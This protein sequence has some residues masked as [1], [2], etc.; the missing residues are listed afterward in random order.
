[1]PIRGFEKAYYRVWKPYYKD[2]NGLFEGLGRPIRGIEGAY[3]R[4]W[5]NLSKGLEWSIRGIGM[6]Y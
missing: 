2:L 5:R 6:A 3:Y 1:M 4:V